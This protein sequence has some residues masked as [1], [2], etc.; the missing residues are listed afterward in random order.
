MWNLPIFINTEPLQNSL[1][2]L[3]LELNLWQVPQD[4]PA[5]FMAFKGNQKILVFQGS[6][7]FPGCLCKSLS[8]K[9]YGTASRPGANFVEVPL[10]ICAMRGINSWPQRFA[11]ET[12][13]PQAAF[14]LLK[15]WE[16]RMKNSQ[17]L[18]PSSSLLSIGD[19]KFEQRPNDRNY[20][21]LNPRSRN[22]FLHIELGPIMAKCI[23]QYRW[24]WTQKHIMRPSTFPIFKG[25]W[26]LLGDALFEFTLLRS[27][28]LRGV[29]DIFLKWFLSHPCWHWRGTETERSWKL[30]LPCSFL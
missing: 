1:L 24:S 18:P 28:N 16:G 21:A 25:S 22:C 7:G 11:V 12:T 27:S 6:Q 23:L 10:K 2:S 30:L 19:V 29:P 14:F 17:H 3:L 9:W 26:F 20:P 13:K 4:Y 15:I 5:I 8:K